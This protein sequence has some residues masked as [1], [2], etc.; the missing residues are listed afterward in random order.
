M[1]PKTLYVPPIFL[2]QNF[3]RNGRRYFMGNSTR[4][5]VGRSIC[6]QEYFSKT[7][8]IRAPGLTIHSAKYQ[9]KLISRIP[10]NGG[11]I[12]W[13]NNPP[14]DRKSTRLNSSHVAI[15]YA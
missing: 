10:N 11:I 9:S 5:R 3:H 14:P 1:I 7:N 12:L 8:L 4:F 15:S 13:N 6:Q 2:L